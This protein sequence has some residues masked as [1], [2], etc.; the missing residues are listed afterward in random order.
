MQKRNNKKNEKCLKTVVST[1]KKKDILTLRTIAAS[2]CAKNAL[3]GHA[4]LFQKQQ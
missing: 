4:E 2:S 1:A 3:L